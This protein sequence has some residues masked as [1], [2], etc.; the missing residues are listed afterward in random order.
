VLGFHPVQSSEP[1]VVGEWMLRVRTDGDDPK[2]KENPRDEGMPIMLAIA[3]DGAKLSGTA[4]VWPAV[5]QADGTVAEDPSKKIVLD[6]I[7]PKFDG[8]TFTFSVFNSEE[9]LV[10]ELKMEGGALTGRW[11]S[12]KSKLAGTL[13]MA[14]R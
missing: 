12:M 11:I 14:K 13:V 9:T 1:A 7:D 5:R 2:H 3:W 4:T 10:G 8:T 6:L